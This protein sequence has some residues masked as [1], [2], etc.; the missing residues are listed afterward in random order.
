MFNIIR[1]SSGHKF[2]CFQQLLRSQYCSTCFHHHWIW[3]T[4]LNQRKA[5]LTEERTN[6]FSHH[7][8]KGGTL[9]N[10][11][12]S[13]AVCS[14]E[15]SSKARWGDVFSERW[16]NDSTH[17]VLLWLGFDTTTTRLKSCGAKLLLSSSHRDALR[18]WTGQ[19]AYR[20]VSSPPFIQQLIH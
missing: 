18:I 19:T 2:N 15:H 4:L 1:L 8:N 3:N 9:Q 17:P 7:Y 20:W 11:F 10:T 6:P 5:R 12:S 16:G 13:Q 14:A